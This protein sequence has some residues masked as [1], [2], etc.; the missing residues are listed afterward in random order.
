MLDANPHRRYDLPA[1]TKTQNKFN[2]CSSPDHNVR[3]CG[4]FLKLSTRDRGQLF[5]QIRTC[6]DKHHTLL[7]PEGYNQMPRPQQ[8]ISTSHICDALVLATMNFTACSLLS[9]I[10]NRTTPEAYEYTALFITGFLWQKLL[11]PNT[12][13]FTS[14]ESTMVAIIC[15]SEREDIQISGGIVKTP[16]YTI[17]GLYILEFEVTETHLMESASV[18]GHPITQYIE[19]QDPLPIT[20]PTALIS[21]PSAF[22]TRTIVYSQVPWMFLLIIAELIYFYQSHPIHRHQCLIPRSPLQ[23]SFPAPMTTNPA[24]PLCCCQQRS[25]ESAARHTDHTMSR[26]SSTPTPKSTS[27]TKVWWKS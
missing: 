12:W 11:M 1:A 8:Q 27:S 18:M 4:G 24:N 16:F 17:G 15:N 22:A 21:G 20:N 26:H 6:G 14:S 13:L 7:H 19:L 9:T 23:C 2:F 5:Q 3:R 25:T 10:Y